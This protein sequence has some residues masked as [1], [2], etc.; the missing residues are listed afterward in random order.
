MW[1]FAQPDPQLPRDPGIVRRGALYVVVWIPVQQS[2]E[3]RYLRGDDQP[4]PNFLRRVDWLPLVTG[5]FLYL[6][7]IQVMTSLGFQQSDQDNRSYPAADEKTHKGGWN[8]PEGWTAVFTG[9]LTLSTIGLW[10]ATYRIAYD[11]KR[12]SD[13]IR[14]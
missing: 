10:W 6:L 1:F 3:R 5:A 12:T 7:A 13:R 9:A 8:T 4:M 14:A 2:R 11:Q